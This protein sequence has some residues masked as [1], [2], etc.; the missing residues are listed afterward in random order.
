H[1]TT[2]ASL[3]IHGELDSQETPLRRP[4]YTRPIMKPNPYAF[5]IR[6]EHIPEDIL[7]VD[8]IHRAVRRIFE[9]DGDEGPVAPNVKVINISIG[10]LSRPF[11]RQMS[12]WAKLLDFLSLKYNVL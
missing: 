2:M 4:L 1:G 10:D 11:D 5:G 9:G 6:S 12:P 8:L 3:I 7:P